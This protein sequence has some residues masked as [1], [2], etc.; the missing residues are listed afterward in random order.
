[1]DCFKF[2][3]IILITFLSVNA[4]CEETITVDFTL[5][6]IN[7]DLFEL[8]EYIGSGPILLDFWATWCKPC[9]D[10][11]PNLQ[12]FHDNY[13]E[14]GLTVAAISIDSPRSL[15][16]IKPFIKSRRYTFKILLDPNGEIL[17]QFQGK[18]IPF[19][20][21]IDKDGKVV[22]THTGYSPGD[23]KILEKKIQELLK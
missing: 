6:D 8:K 13:E 5:E 11:M 23:E 15:N 17:Q 16:K 21:L 12:M 7:G 3:T 20:V 4:H 10:A 22:E 14:Q 2:A 9:K 1:M 19:Q 18:N